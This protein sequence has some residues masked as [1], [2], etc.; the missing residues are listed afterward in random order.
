MLDISSYVLFRIWLQTP[1]SFELS[2]N[3][4]AIR[5]ENKTNL[6]PEYR[7]ALEDITGKKPF[8]CSLKANFPH[9]HLISAF[10]SCIRKHQPERDFS[11]KIVK[12]VQ[13]GS[14]HLLK[15]RLPFFLHV[16]SHCPRNIVV[17]VGKSQGRWAG[18]Y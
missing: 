8:L 9:C 6:L 14:S 17:R 7:K 3:P 5:V 13:N 18:E 2:G 16:S 12:K 10:I 1:S 4:Q 11:K 15:G